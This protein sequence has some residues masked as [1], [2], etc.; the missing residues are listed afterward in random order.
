MYQMASA[1]MPQIIVCII[2]AA[3]LAMLIAG[4]LK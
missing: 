3:G 2:S 4:A 1:D